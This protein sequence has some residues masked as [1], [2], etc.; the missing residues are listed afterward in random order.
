MVVSYLAKR[1]F[2]I[3]NPVTSTI[4][5]SFL[6]FTHAVGKFKVSLCVL[7]WYNHNRMHYCNIFKTDCIWFSGEIVIL[8][9]KGWEVGIYYILPLTVTATQVRIGSRVTVSENL[10]SYCYCHTQGSAWALW[11]S[12]CNSIYLM[13]SRIRDCLDFW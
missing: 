3:S 8:S 12:K 9:M 11:T 4:N 5:N 6:L 2:N 7:Q 1:L 13:H 10:T